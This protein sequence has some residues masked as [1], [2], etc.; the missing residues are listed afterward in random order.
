MNGQ[1][2]RPPESSDLEAWE[3][4]KW[5]AAVIGLP[6]LFVAFIIWLVL[7]LLR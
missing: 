7:S 3:S 2:W 4:V 1:P 6:L 5:L